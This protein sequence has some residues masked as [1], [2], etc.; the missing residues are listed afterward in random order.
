MTT[1]ESS[2][3]PLHPGRGTNVI[4]V[5]RI[6][7]G[8]VIVLV[9]LGIFG[10]LLTIIAVARC[11]FLQQKQNV[12]LVSLAV[13]DIHSVC[14][15][16]V[17]MQATP[18]DKYYT[19]NLGLLSTLLLNS[20]FISATHILF[21]GI[22]RVIAITWPLHYPRIVTEKTLAIAIVTAWLTPAVSLVPAY[23]YV[24]KTA[25]SDQDRKDLLYFH[26]VFCFVTYCIFAIALCV[27]YGKIYYDTQ[28]QVNKV[29]AMSAIPGNDPSPTKHPG[30]KKAMKM[31]LVI[32]LAFLILDFPYVLHGLQ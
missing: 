4:I 27:T 13:S 1:A 15:Y 18:L 10:N 21:I 28:A 19:T 32:L 3:D 12:L 29:H 8:L 31:V 7:L 20:G 9:I 17:D 2:A 23:L 26:Y 22:E 30:N 25:E 16:V 6:Q 24:I 5:R 11:R 14:M